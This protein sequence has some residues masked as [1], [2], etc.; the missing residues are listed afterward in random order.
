MVVYPGKKEDITSYLL[1]EKILKWIPKLSIIGLILGK[2]GRRGLV[3]A[4]K[5]PIETILDGKSE[6]NLNSLRNFATSIRVDKIAMAGRLPH[7]VLE[8]KSSN[9]LFVKGKRGTIFAIL[10]NVREVMEKE[11]L[12]SSTTK[13]GVLGTGF[14]GM[15]LLTQLQKSGFDTVIGV[16]PRLKQP[17]IGEQVKIGSNPS[18]LSECD[19]VVVLTPKGDD[20]K[21][22]IPHLKEGVIVV[23]DTHPSISKTN[24]LRIKSRRGKTYKVALTLNGTKFVPSLAGYINGKL[25]PGCVIEVLV[26][27][28][29]KHQIITQDEFNKG[30]REMEF[31]VSLLDLTQFG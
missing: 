23:D 9:S 16:D 7:L 22:A 13:I 29:S 26:L 24:L 6:E 8:D 30:A 4:I 14:I 10:E 25:L 27:N 1:S 11:G 17:R 28:G 19:L 18:L 20:I 3:I 21:D 12:S 31:R 5:N 2:K 15:A